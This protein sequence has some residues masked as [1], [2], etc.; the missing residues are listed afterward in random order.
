MNIDEFLKLCR[1]VTDNYVKA[2]GGKLWPPND[3]FRKI[4]EEYGELADA[5]NNLNELEEGW[6]VIFAVLT[7][8]HT[9]KFD[10]YA[11]KQSMLSTLRKITDRSEKVKNFNIDV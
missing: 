3:Q 8:F 5:T 9:K 7:Y 4:A 10:D 2:W 6:D 11:I 1:Q